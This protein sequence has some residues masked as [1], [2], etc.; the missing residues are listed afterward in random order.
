MKNETYGYHQH[1]NINT[2]NK[3]TTDQLQK[4]IR[5]EDGGELLDFW[6]KNSS[7]RPDIWRFVC[8]NGTTED[9]KLL[10]KTRKIESSLILESVL[11]LLKS[12]DRNKLFH[13]WK[14][15]P[16]IRLDIWLFICEHG[17]V[18]DI[19]ML[20]K[21]GKVTLL[22]LLEGTEVLVMRKS[23]DM[24]VLISQDGSNTEIFRTLLKYKYLDLLDEYV[25]ATK[26]YLEDYLIE[27][28][29][30]EDLDAIKC[31]FKH[32]AQF[33]TKVLRNLRLELKSGIVK[34]P[35][36]IE[37]AKF[38]IEMDFSFD[39]V[40]VILAIK[41]KRLDVASYLIT[42]TPYDRDELTQLGDYLMTLEDKDVIGSVK[43]LLRPIANT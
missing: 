43:A 26:Q 42:N 25:G 7:I 22:L 37:T 1:E 9:T 31:V 8:K 11:E 10:M 29:R 23:L 4:L 30:L 12:K 39:I 27:S 19:K 38:L 35:S 5:K 34:F 40:Y 2:M 20:M 13:I 28:V 3:G 18:E 16:G 14:M 41:H 36:N 17:E 6:K 21:T 24:L 32:G 33:T 15:N